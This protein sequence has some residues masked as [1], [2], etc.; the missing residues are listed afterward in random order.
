M[1]N[2]FFTFLPTGQHD[3]Y[4]CFSHVKESDQKETTDPRIED[5]PLHA[6]LKKPVNLFENLVNLKSVSYLR[7]CVA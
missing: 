6:D 1:L 3:C 4:Y 7:I 5:A 2:F